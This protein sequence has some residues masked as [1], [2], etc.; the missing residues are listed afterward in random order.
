MDVDIY[1]TTAEILAGC[2]A[3]DCPKQ[4]YDAVLNW[5]LS[6]L[7]RQTESNRVFVT[8]HQTGS[9]G[10]AYYNKYPPEFEYFKPV[11][12]TVQIAKCSDEELNNAYDNTIRYTDSL[13]ADLI[14]QLERM[15]DVN[16]TLIYVSDHGQSLGEDGYYL[17]G[18]PIAFAPIEQR[19]IPF[20]VWMSDGFQQSR[21]LSAATILRDETFPHD[22]PFHSVMGAFGLRSDIYK[23][24]F[25]IF[26]IGKGNF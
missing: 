16:A 2:T 5:Q 26:N 18:A 11:C 4:G 7:I 13:I 15:T 1:Q 20:L 23:P 8:L 17:H 19:E 12:K 22:F 21:G 25:D 14:T 9:H 10:P 24:Q 3:V 6:D